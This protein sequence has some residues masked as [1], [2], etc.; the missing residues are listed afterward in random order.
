MFKQL[1]DIIEVSVN[2]AGLGG[3]FEALT[4][5][6]EYKKVARSI[7]GDWAVENLV[8]KYFKN[9]LLYVDAK[10]ASWSQNLHINH[11]QIINTINKGLEKN[12]LKKIIIKNKG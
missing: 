3:E 10:N 8:P 4:V 12:L 6:N 2:R 7:L 5:I 1:K 9:G 11:I